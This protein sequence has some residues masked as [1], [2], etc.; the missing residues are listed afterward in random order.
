M[1]NLLR[2]ASALLISI[3][4]L[5]AVQVQA[6]A[7]ESW[8]PSFDSSQHVYI[9]PAVQGSVRTDFAIGDFKSELADA[10]RKQ[11]LDVYV[12]VTRSEADAGAVNGS[13]P[14]LVRK[15]W[16]NWHSSSSFS[17]QRALVILIT[18]GSDGKLVSVGVRAG[19]TLNTLGIVRNTMSDP[20]GPVIPVLRSDLSSN[21]SAVPVKIVN[22]ISAIIAAK[23]SSSTA[24]TEGAGTATAIS[25]SNEEESSMPIALIL[26]VGGIV[27]AA[28]VILVIRAN[29]K[30]AQSTSG[31]VFEDRLRSSSR[32]PSGTGDSVN[33]GSVKPSGSESSTARDATILGAGALGGYV[34]GSE[35]QRRRDEERRRDSGTQSSTTTSDTPYVA[36]ASNCSTPT[37]PSA[38]ASSCSAP[39]SS[40]G[41]G[42]SSCGGGGSSCGGGS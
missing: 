6:Q 34:L 41:G 25:N 40:C 31:N 13:G 33:D 7:S 19:E 16:D 30:P 2:V 15:L 27:V 20:N 5:G 28:I 22:N 29:R 11:N 37:T 26:L 18:G 35:V 42:G 14:V 38:P 8:L 3:V 21:P 36:P 23:T 10:A 1:K 39:S 4:S 12:I 24:V 17:S 32:K 9:A